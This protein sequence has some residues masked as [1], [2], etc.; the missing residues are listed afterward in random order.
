MSSAAGPADPDPTRDLLDNAPCGLLATLPDGRIVTV[1]STLCTWLGLSREEL[2]G[3]SFGDLL[4][5]GSRIHFETHFA[6]LLQMDG[7]LRG[8]AVDLV[9]ADGSRWPV[10]LSANTAVGPDGR[11]ALFR[12]TVQDGNDRRAYERELLAA[13]KRAE[14]EQ[15]RAEHLAATLQRSLL[16]PALS[17]PPGL[18]AAATYHAAAAD[19]GGDFY[20]LFPLTRSKWGF[21]LG[22]VCGKGAA[23]AALT[24]LTRYTLR[25]AAVYDDDPVAVLHNLDIVFTQNDMD[26]QNSFCTVLF[27]IITVRG[28]TGFDVEMATGGHPPG[29]LIRADGA[30]EYVEIAGGHAVGLFSGPRFVSTHLHLRTGDTLFLYTDGLTEARIG[31]GAERYDDDGALLNFVATHAPTTATQIVTAVEGVLAGLRVD[32]DVAVLALSAR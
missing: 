3:R 25:A 10:F 14:F 8:I 15:A 18:D 4:S 27:G 5:V 11:P 16:P 29:I 31:S 21:F 19:V 32:D 26:G 23:A 24:S 20:D 12:I 9:G 2:T 6:A 22:D 28:D 7:Q 1:N 30:T 13:R 17:P